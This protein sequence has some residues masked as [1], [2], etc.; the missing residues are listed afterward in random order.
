MRSRG[1]NLNSFSGFTLVE[2]VLAMTIFALMGTI[3]SGAFYLG[4]GAA[5]KTEARFEESRR[6]R[7]VGDLLGSYIRSSYPYRPSVEDAA[8]FYN[9]EESRLTFIS[10]L[11][12][13]MGGSGMAKVSVSWD[14]G[15]E[16]EGVLTLVEEVPVRVESEVEG[17]IKNQLVLREGVTDLRLEYLDPQSEEELWSERWEGKERRVLPRAVRLTYRGRGGE[18]SRW[19]FPIMIHVLAP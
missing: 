9:G 11:S 18:E 8:I 19:V 10:A 16:G 13:G 4:H 3:L 15:G 12:F 5:A 14:A 7:S 1:L 17:G 2:V 6:V